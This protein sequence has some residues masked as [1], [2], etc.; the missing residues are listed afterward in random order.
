MEIPPNDGEL[1]EGLILVDGRNSTGKTSLFEAILWCLWGSSAISPLKN[2]DIIRKGAKKVTVEV[3]FEVLGEKFKIYRSYSRSEGMKAILYQ[4]DSKIN[5]FRDIKTKS[6]EVEAKI[7]E[8]LG[9]GYKQMLQTFA[10]RQGEVAHLALAPPHV[11]RNEIQDIF[12]LNVLENVSKK[13]EI[14]EKRLSIRLDNINRRIVPKE[15]LQ[16]DIKNTLKKIEEE[17][18][19]LEGLEKKIKEKKKELKKYPSEKILSEILV[20]LTRLFSYKRILEEEMDKSKDIPYTLND[21]RKKLKKLEKELNRIYSDMEDGKRKIGELVGV[22]NSLVERKEKL[23]ELKEKGEKQCPLCGS[24]LTEAHFKKL[25]KE[26]TEKINQLEREIKTKEEKLINLDEQYEEKYNEYEKLKEHISKLEQIEEH[27]KRVKQS[28]E[29]LKEVLSVLNVKNVEELLNMY[30]VNSIEKLREK[31]SHL[32]V[33]IKRLEGECIGKKELINTLQQEVKKLE[34][35]MKEVE[36]LEEEKEKLTKIINH[37]SYLRKFLIK[38]FLTDY[39]TNRKLLGYLKAASSRILPYIT[40]G[41][42][43]T[44]YLEATEA[45]GRGAS[46]LRI[47]VKDERDGINKPKEM[48]SFGDKTAVGFALR[49]AILM[50]LSR[51][52]PMKNSKKPQPKVNLILLDEPLLGLDEER[53]QKI[54]EM[55]LNEKKFKQIFLITHTRVNIPSHRITVYKENGQSKI[56]YQLLTLKH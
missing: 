21:A 43:T 17:T 47:L 30:G 11:L 45:K 55:L 4:Y 53:R 8:L 56:K 32:N 34:E 35:R 14:E 26:F 16:E 10:I 24:K 28:E 37:L 25:E 15:R 19:N 5:K 49:L 2:E 3:T 9:I 27:K 50:I 1:P 40:N 18:K 41:Q 33:E 20:S 44:L 31:I 23:H 7:Q 54:V 38:G 29:K 51:L 42:Y 39:I 12:S 48:L 6:K 36:K 22:K 52:R 13:I 46:G